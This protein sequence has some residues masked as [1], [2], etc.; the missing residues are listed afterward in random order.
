MNLNELETIIPLVTNIC[1]IVSILYFLYKYKMI[2]IK[3]ICFGFVEYLITQ[4]VYSLILS[5]ITVFFKVQLYTMFK[6]LLLVLIF[7]SIRKT[8]YKKI[9]KPNLTKEYISLGLGVGLNTYINLMLPTIFN[10]LMYSVRIN[11]GSIFQNMLDK[12]YSLMEINRYIEVF[13][14]NSSNYYIFTAI[15]CLIPFLLHIGISL[16][17]QKNVNIYKVCIFGILFE[18][19]YYI[20]PIYNYLLANVLIIITSVC[21]I[22]LINYKKETFY[23]RKILSK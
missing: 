2:N 20:V 5:F 19:I 8:L 23:V 4:V 16:L 14:A 22:L 10:N 7:V 12:G 13:N 11:N 18:S 17:I 3:F 21:F 6:V 9:Y 1:V 15:C